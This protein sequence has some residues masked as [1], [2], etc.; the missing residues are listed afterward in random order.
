MPIKYWI[1][2]D[3]RCVRAIVSGE[4]TIDDIFQAIKDS[5]EDVDF[6][7]G[8]DVLSDHTNVGEPLTTQQATQLSSYLKNMSSVMAH[9]RWAVVTKDPASFGMMRM[10]SVF[11]QE[12]PMVLKIFETLE[13]GEKWLFQSKE[14]QRPPAEPGV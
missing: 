1:D 8:F 13:E 9:A 12:V 5:T 10:L 7:P 6:E 2:K 4:F 11:L 3:H 14:N